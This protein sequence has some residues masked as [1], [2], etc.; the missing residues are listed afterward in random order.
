M[1]SAIRVCCLAGLLPW[2]FMPLAATA[3]DDIAWELSITDGDQAPLARI[4]LE[5]SGHW[6]LIWNH[7][8]QGFPVIDCF[9]VRN[10]RLT[11]HSS[12]APDFA[13]GLGHIAGRGTLESDSQHGYRIV[14]MD[15]PIPGNTLRLRVGSESVNHRIRT[16]NRT[17]SLSHLAAN[18]PVQIRLT[19]VGD[20]GIELQ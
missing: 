14:D 6:C 19:P 17:I 18:Q 3:G 11:L 9:S 7:S 2:V 10:E 1:R 16:G 15:V 8:V 12:Q 4:G 13:A 5:D 20:K